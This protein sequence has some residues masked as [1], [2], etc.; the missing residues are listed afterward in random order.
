MEPLGLRVYRTKTKVQAFGDIVDASI[1][2]FS[3]SGE[4]E[5]RLS[6]TFTYLGSVNHSSTKL[7]TKSVDDWDEP[8]AR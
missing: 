6:Q 3:V 8:G 4:I 5:I 2:S 1:E 7:R